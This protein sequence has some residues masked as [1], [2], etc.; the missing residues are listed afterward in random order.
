ML[1]RLNLQKSLCLSMHAAACLT[2]GSACAS[3]TSTSVGSSA[4]AI[5]PDCV[6]VKPGKVSSLTSGSQ[7]LC[8]Q[9]TFA[10]G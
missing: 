2:L 5:C 8:V 7:P 6:P 3:E 4:P 9:S 10:T 1:T